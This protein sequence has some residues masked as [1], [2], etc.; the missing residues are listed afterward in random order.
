MEMLDRLLGEPIRLEISYGRDMWPVLADLSQIEQVVI[1]LSVNARD[2]MPGGGELKIRTRNVPQGAAEP[3][4]DG[5]PDGD[6]VLIEIED[7]GTGMPQHVLDKIFEPFFTTKAMGEGTGLGLS[8]VYGIIKQ[9]GGFIFV[10]SVVDRGT[11][12]TLYFPVSETR[13]EEARPMAEAIRAPAPLHGEGVVLLVEDEAPVRAFASRALRLRGYTVLEAES[14]EEALSM[15][16]DPDLSVDVFVT[17][18]VMPGLDGPS[19]VREARKVRP[20]VRVV[21]VSGY[22]EGAFGNAEPPVPNSVFLPKP[23]SLSELTAT[24]AAQIH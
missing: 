4:D 15:L 13:S 10:D 7:V 22:A 12:F 9:T 3:G 2:A 20:D 6:A 21:F 8:T 19:W 14:A 17:D 16:D 11:S 23:F 18:V 24:V 5:L 1:N